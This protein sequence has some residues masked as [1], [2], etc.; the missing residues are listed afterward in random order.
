MSG[1]V[2]VANGIVGNVAV[3]IQVLRIACPRDYG[4]RLYK[5]AQHRIVIP[6]PIVHQQTAGVESLPCKSIVGGG[7]PFA[8][9]NAAEGIVGLACDQRPA[10]I[11][12]YDGRTEMI[13]VEVKHARV[14]L[15]RHTRRAK[16]ALR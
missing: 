11:H 13:V 2:G 16:A 5:P 10:V 7:C 14:I 6:C 4:I 1:W 3:A 8:G 9:A 15:Q 12:H